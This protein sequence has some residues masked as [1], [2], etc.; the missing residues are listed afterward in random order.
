MRNDEILLAVVS[1][2]LDEGVLLAARCTG[3]RCLKR[4]M[5]EGIAK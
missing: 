4:E 3:A 1:T 5:L 2:V